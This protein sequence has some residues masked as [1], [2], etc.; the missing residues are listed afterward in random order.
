MGIEFRGTVP[1]LI[2]RHSLKS[3]Q[4]P[5]MSSTDFVQRTLFQ[6]IFKR[7]VGEPRPFFMDHCNLQVPSNA[8]GSPYKPTWFEIRKVCPGIEDNAW[9]SFPSGHTG[10]S[11]A[12]GTFL[13]L[14]LNAKL[15]AFSNYH[16]SFWKQM[17]VLAPLL[18]AALVSI[19]MIVD[20]VSQNPARRISSYRPQR[21]NS[22]SRSPVTDRASR[23]IIP[24]MSS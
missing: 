2:I 20:C 12:A 4:K 13:A 3:L 10:S 21:G 15:K 8:I 19:G 16:T 7:F 24:T 11:F 17:C 22:S 23:T 14:Y 9:Q 5:L 6:E 1:R 18:G